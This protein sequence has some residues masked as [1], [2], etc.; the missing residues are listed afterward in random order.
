MG[1]PAASPAATNPAVGP[2]TR[3][4]SRP[5]SPTVPAPTKH[6]ARRWAS[7]VS[8]PARETTLS[9]PGNS[10]GYSAVGRTVSTRARSY[11]RM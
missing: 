4:P 6:M 10:G 7:T 5:I 9:R 1:Y 2:A 8:P 3:R 11:G